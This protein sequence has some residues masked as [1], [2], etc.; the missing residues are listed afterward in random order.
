M[1]MQVHRFMCIDPCVC[2]HVGIM[3]SCV[4]THAGVCVHVYVCMRVCECVHV[5][6]VH[7]CVEAR[8]QPGVSFLKRYPFHCFESGSP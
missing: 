7:V 2:T 4:C 3:Y 1:Y 5:G 6:G 8:G